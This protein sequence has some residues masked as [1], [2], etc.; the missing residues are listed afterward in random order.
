M[1]KIIALAA[2]LGALAY[3]PATTD[4]AQKKKP[5]TSSQTKPKFDPYKLCQQLVAKHGG[6]VP[7]VQRYRIT[8]DGTLHCWYMV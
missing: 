7:R 6:P 1:R 5:S 2:L 3:M 4:A 8:K